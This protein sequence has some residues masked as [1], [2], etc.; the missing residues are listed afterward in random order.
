[1]IVDISV[2]EVRAGREE[3]FARAFREAWKKLG[4]VKGLGKWRLLR[5]VE[6]PTRFVFY[7]EWKSI[8]DHQ[9]LAKTPGYGALLAAVGPYME[10]S[11]EILHYAPVKR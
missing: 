8:E 7:G 2:V 1:M 5:C 4:R 9:A 11:P 3:E 6:K 10:G